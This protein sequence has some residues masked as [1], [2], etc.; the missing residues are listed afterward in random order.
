MHGLLSPRF[1]ELGIGGPLDHL[2]SYRQAVSDQQ[3]FHWEI[4]KQI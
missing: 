3:Q 2:A 1:G 4:D